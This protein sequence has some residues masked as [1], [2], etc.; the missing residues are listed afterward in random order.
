MP[1]WGA[2]PRPTRLLE[3]GERRIEERNIEDRERE[4]DEEEIE[5]LD[6]IR[7]SGFTCTSPN[8]KER[9]DNEG[10]G[11]GRLNCAHVGAKYRIT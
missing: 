6:S 5:A 4:K 3:K 1:V 2:I 8:E 9:S 10:E 7:S 11:V